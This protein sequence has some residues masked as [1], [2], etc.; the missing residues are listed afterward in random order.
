MYI[1]LYHTCKSCTCDI[2][3]KLEKTGFPIFLSHGEWYVENSEAPVI[4]FWPC[5]TP[6]MTLF[7]MVFEAQNGTF[8]PISG[9]IFE[10]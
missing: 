1:L 7:F 5:R 9:T 8:Y 6:K 2:L 3:L 10:E 4:G